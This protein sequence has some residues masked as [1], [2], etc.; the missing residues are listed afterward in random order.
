M[1]TLIITE[2]PSVARDFAKALKVGTKHDGYLESPEYVVTW[3]LGHLVELFEPQDYDSRLKSWR[4]ELLPVIPEAFNYKPIRKTAKQLKIIAKL[5]GLPSVGRVVIATDAGREGEVIARTIL[6]TVP[7]KRPMPPL[8]RFWTS[9]ALTPQVVRDGMARLSPAHMYDRLWRAGQARQIADWLVGMNGSRVATLKMND[10]FSIGRVQTAVLALLVERFK[11]RKE[12]KPEPYW[13]LSARFAGDKGVWWGS[14]FKEK[15]T[16]FTEKEKALSVLSAVENMEAEVLSVKKTRKK[17]PPPLLYSLTDLQQDANRRYHFSAKRTLDIAQGLYE[18][19]KCLSYPRT[20]SKVLGSKNVSMVSGIVDKFQQVYGKTFS[21]I[22]RGLISAGNRRVFNDAKLTDHH[23]LIPLAPLPQNA[24]PDETRIYHLVLNRFAAAFYPDFEYEQTEIITLAAR[25]VTFRTRGKITLKE[26]WKAVYA[27]EAKSKKKAQEGEEEE[28]LPP[29]EKGDGGRVQETKLA[30]KMTQPPPE[31]NEALLLK[32]MTN[33]G[34]YVSE[35]DLKKIFR[36]DVGL[37]TQ[38]TRAQIIET[39]LSREYITREKKHLIPLE[40]GIVLIDTLA[41]FKT[42]K[43]LASPEET[44]R[45][46][47]K[48]EEIAMGKEGDEKFIDKIKTFVRTIVD[49][50]KGAQLKAFSGDSEKPLGRCPACGKNIMEGRKAYGCEGFR[51]E[52]NGCSFAIWKRIAGKRI[53]RTIALELLQKGRTGIIKGFISKKKKK[54]SACLVLRREQGKLGVGFEFPG[55]FSKGKGSGKSAATSNPAGNARG[56]RGNCRQVPAGGYSPPDGFNLPPSGHSG[57]DGFNAPASGY[58][59]PD[60]FY[61]S[62]SGHAGP[63]NYNNAPARDTDRSSASPRPVHPPVRGH[64]GG[65]LNRG[66]SPDRMPPTSAAPSRERTQMQGRT[67]GSAL[68]RGPSGATG[69]VPSGD[70]GL[71]RLGSCPVCG[72]KIIEGKR[73][74]GCSNWPARAGACKFVIWKILLEKKLTE[75][76]IRTLVSGKTTRSY[77]FK[78]PSGSKFRAKLK[79]E[80]NPSSGAWEPVFMDRKPY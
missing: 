49:E 4:L 54:F 12:F 21:G 18:R 64:A 1:K 23:A 16:R 7:P 20:D 80:R 55:S 3:A 26:G 30:E 22:D 35:N 71:H 65:A 72:G 56:G 57:P 38:A 67:S 32:D 69:T 10:L 66:P 37:G 8:F 41:G 52:E 36:G 47:M 28:N 33:P 48:L 39:L 40:K 29:L 63:G 11:A 13:L 70:A 25:E 9:Q 78:E 34:R 5:L 15:E 51:N 79:L 27:S 62:A 76:N 17:T 44:A 68:D 61:V 73:G 50:F 77:V 19:K 53:S 58:S 75:D 31:Y 14:W 74:Y 43:I 46:E 60:D 24:N 6:E 59:G 42:A 2:K 45:W